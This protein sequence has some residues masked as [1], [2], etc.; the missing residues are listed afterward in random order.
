MR[1]QMYNPAV[2]L[3]F[4]KDNI[5]YNVMGKFQDPR[6]H[7]NAGMTLCTMQGKRSSWDGVITVLVIISMREL[8]KKLWLS[9]GLHYSGME[10]FPT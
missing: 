3:P 8:S 5:A 9:P 4:E 10:H 6:K 2:N 7:A 1:L